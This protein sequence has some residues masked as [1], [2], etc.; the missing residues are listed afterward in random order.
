MITK[1]EAMKDYYNEGYSHGY[2]DGYYNAK[3]DYAEK[4]NKIRNL[5][6]ETQSK[7]DEDTDHD[8]IVRFGLMLAYQIINKVE[9]E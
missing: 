9:G 5:I 8:D 6:T 3:K 7:Y 2:I 1:K 4:M